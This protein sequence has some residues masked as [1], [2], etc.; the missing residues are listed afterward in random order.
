MRKSNLNKKRYTG[1]LEVDPLQSNRNKKGSSSK[2]K[3]QD[4]STRSLKPPA[5]D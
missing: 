3:S 2:G 4:K 5:L 1:Q